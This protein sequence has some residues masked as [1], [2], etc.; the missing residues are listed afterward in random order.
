MAGEIHR[1]YSAWERITPEH[2]EDALLALSW[3]KN[4]VDITQFFQYFQGSYMG[5][6]YDAHSPPAAYFPNSSGCKQFANFI[7]SELENRIINGSMEVVGRVGEVDPPHLVMPLCVEPSKPRLCH[8]Q[9]F[10]NLFI[11]DNPFKLDTL[12]DVPRLISQGVCLG[13]TDDK[14]G[15]DHVL[16]TENSKTYFG[17]QWAGWYLTFNSLPFGFKA[18]AFVYQSIGLLATNYIRSLNVPVLQYIDDRLIGE[19]LG[20]LESAVGPFIADRAHIGLYIA[21]EVLTRLGYFLA[22]KK[23]VLYPTQAIRFLGFVIDTVQEAF[24]VPQDKRENFKKLRCSILAARSVDVRTL[25]RFVGKCISFMLAIP[26]AKLFTREINAAISTGLRHNARVKLEGKLREEIQYWEFLDDWQEVMPWK[27]E[28]HMHIV[29]ATDA[30]LYKWGAVIAVGSPDEVSTGDD[31][32]GDD[33]RPIHL[34]EASA[35]LCA[36][37]SV[38]RGDIVNTRVDAHVDSKVLVDVWNGQGGKLKL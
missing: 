23:S 10:L 37:Q 11:R 27:R 38:P 29:M 28:H 2:N 17:V 26:G 16:V 18:S 20:Q 19:W 24:I 25:Q 9:R 4:K 34:K 33:N 15:Y 13:S 6:F 7:T 5:S 31:W 1:H 35:L 30:S 14:S 12:C 8:D 21:C 22:V 36:L 3:V 32:R